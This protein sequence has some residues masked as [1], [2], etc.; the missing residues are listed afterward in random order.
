MAVYRDCCRDRRGNICQVVPRKCRHL[1]SQNHFSGYPTNRALTRNCDSF[2]REVVHWFAFLVV[3]DR[4]I[5]TRET[6]IQ[7]SSGVMAESR[8]NREFYDPY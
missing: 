4:G 6:G 8:P 1:T 2:I 5:Q 3:A 7:F